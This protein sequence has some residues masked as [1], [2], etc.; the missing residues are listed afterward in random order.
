MQ[1][2]PWDLL[3]GLAQS[4]C[5]RGC[6]S[7]CH[8]SPIAI[9]EHQLSHLENFRLEFVC[10]GS[11]MWPLVLRDLLMAPESTVPTDQDPPI[12]KGQTSQFLPLL[13]SPYC[14]PKR[15]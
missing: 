9:P 10:W 2:H 3:Q 11:S 15:P 8:V 1:G 12:S 4:G 5:S 14:F 6:P 7:S 13:S